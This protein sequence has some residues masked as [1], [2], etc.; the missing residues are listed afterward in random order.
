ML[1]ENIEYSEKYQLVKLKI[2]GEFFYI[3]Y[4]FYY[5]L[6]IAKDDE[7]DFDIFKQIVDQDQFNRC[8]N[9]ALKQVSY[10]AITSLDIRKKLRDKKYT[11]ENIDKT[12]DYLKKYQLVDD[13]AYVRAYIKDKSTLSNWSKNKIY[14]KLK[15]KFLPDD[16]INKYLNMISDDE[17]YKKAILIAKRKAG[18]DLSYENKQKVY[19]FL[20]GRGFSYEIINRCLEEIF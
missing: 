9:Y 12:I 6:N 14:Y 19:R 15:A 11:E 16:L 20:Y 13:E 7:L 18:D 8:K 10:R 1:V 17:E 3:S 2:S 4:D 5:E